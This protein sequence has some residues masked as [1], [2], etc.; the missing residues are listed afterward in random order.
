MI[1]AVP[2]WLSL[3]GGLH[4]LHLHVFLF[5]RFQS[6]SSA[7]AAAT[8][9]DSLWIEKELFFPSDE[10]LFVCLSPLSPG[11]ALRTNSDLQMNLRFTQMNPI[12]FPPSSAVLVTTTNFFSP[13]IC[14][15]AFCNFDRFRRRRC[16]PL[17]Y[18]K[19]DCSV[20]MP[21]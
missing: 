6:T 14:R 13:G 18:A 5:F 12:S 4:R 2:R 8:A 1:V 19:K 7:A 16:D 21:K 11:S 10:N 3:L 17:T 20:P 9:V 15:R